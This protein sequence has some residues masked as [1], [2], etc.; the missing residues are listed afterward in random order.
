MPSWLI[1]IL[2]NLIVRFGLPEI[3]QHWPGSKDLINNLLGAIK[4]S[5]D[6]G[7][8]IAQLAAHVDCISPG[9]GDVLPKS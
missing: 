5:D 1:P 9:P 3:K 6:P 8:S 2:I 7:D 4:N